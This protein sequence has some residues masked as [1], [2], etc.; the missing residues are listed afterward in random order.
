[1]T[2]SDTI[3]TLE[4][5]RELY[6]LLIGRSIPDGFHLGNPPKL[7]PK[8]AFTVI[9]MLQERYHVIPDHF[10]QCCE[11]KQIFDD[12]AEGIHSEKAGKHWCGS[13]SNAKDH[14]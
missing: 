14:P 5:T 10:E 8:K 6:D 2:D 12:W 11:C 4:K 3:M 1:M 7:S 9:Y 13:C